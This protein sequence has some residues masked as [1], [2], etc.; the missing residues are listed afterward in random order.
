MANTRYK[1]PF[2]REQRRD[3]ALPFGNK[4]WKRISFDLPILFRL[5][6]KTA[7]A[8]AHVNRAPTAQSYIA[9]NKEPV[10]DSFVNQPRRDVYE[11]PLHKSFI[12]ARSMLHARRDQA[13][14]LERLTKCY[15]EIFICVPDYATRTINAVV[16]LL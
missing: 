7:K 15:A 3:G 13:K 6:W 9:W 5:S 16:K 14:L 12:F 8:A 10:L 1:P 11:P 2:A 4:R